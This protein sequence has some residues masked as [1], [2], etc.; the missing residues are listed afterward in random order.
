MAWHRHRRQD[1]YY[2]SRRCGE[3]V[4]RIYIGGGNVG[5]MAER[6]DRCLRRERKRNQL[7][8][9]K[10][11]EEL[12]QLLTDLWHWDRHTRRLMQAELLSRGYYLH[13][14]SGWRRR[15]MNATKQD[16][17]NTIRFPASVSST[18]AFA[19]LVERANAGDKVALEELGALLKN[20]PNVVATV[21]DLEA[22]CLDRAL[23]L[24]CAQNTVVR[25]AFRVKM[26]T[27]ERELAGPYPTAAIRHG[28]KRVVMAWLAL[29]A[30]DCRCADASQQND[31][32]R[33]WQ[34]ARDSAERRYLSALRSLE[35]V[36]LLPP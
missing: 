35:L 12:L 18:E 11:T 19:Q 29:Q 26:E 28:A 24:L 10:V 8:R 14:R 33:R 31:I 21:T 20:N 7:A 36:R 34:D 5:V 4:H 30:A 13:H 27:L 6:I 32:P 16:W 15:Q 3:Q 9:R 23:D 2:R 17:P 25:E 22:R 1:V